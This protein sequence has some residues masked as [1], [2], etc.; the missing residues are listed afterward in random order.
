VRKSDAGGNDYLSKEKTNT[1]ASEHKIVN[2][3]N[4]RTMW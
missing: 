2:P 1:R 4:H 3:Y